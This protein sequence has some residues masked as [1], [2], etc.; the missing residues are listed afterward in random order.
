MDNPTA[1]TNS[2]TIKSFYFYVVS[3]VALMMIVWSSADMINIALKTWVF[4]K[5]D[6]NFYDGRMACATIPVPPPVTD[7]KAT[8]PVITKE[9]AIKDCEAQNEVNAKQQEKNRIAQKQQSV[10]HDISMFVVAIP[11]FFIHW[12]IVRR[13]DEDL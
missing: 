9:Q 2:W 8:T 4:T 10:V 6:D 3:F 12:R 7:P 13:K 5:A 1:R 11:L